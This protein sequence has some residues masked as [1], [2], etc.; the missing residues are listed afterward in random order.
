MKKF[1]MLLIIISSVL[2]IKPFAQENRAGKIGIGYSGNFTSNTNELSLSYWVTGVFVIEP[3][4]GFRHI[5]I[6]NN[7]GTTFKPGLGLLVRFNEQ[8][9]SPYAGARFKLNILSGGDDTYTDIILSLV[10]G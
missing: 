1:I 9:V 10:F 6:E 3:Q 2:S 8:T 4:F 5:E 7:S